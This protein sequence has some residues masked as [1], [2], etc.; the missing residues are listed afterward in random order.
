MY[1]VEALSSPEDI[2]KKASGL[3]YPINGEA[4][5]IIISLINLNDPVL[6]YMVIGRDRKEIDKIKELF[7]NAVSIKN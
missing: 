6:G 2:L 4:S 5:G 7:I 1:S 3:L